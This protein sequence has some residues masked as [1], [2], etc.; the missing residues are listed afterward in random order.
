M[1]FHPEVDLTENGK[2]MMKNFLFEVCKLKGDYTMKSREEECIAEIK[3][4]VKDNKVLVS[5]TRDHFPT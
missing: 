1:Q 4:A 3:E 2:T 5:I